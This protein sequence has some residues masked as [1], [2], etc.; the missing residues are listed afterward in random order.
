MIITN[1]DMLHQS[2][3]PLHGQFATLLSNL[4]Y[5]IVDEG[6]AYRQAAFLPASLLTVIYLVTAVTTTCLLLLRGYI[7][8]SDQV[9]IHSREHDIIT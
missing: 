4:K 8:S 2:I 7:P 5:I 6:H 9:A 1:P 3:L